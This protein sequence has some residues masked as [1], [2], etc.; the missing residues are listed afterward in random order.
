MTSSRQMADLLQRR[1]DGGHSHQPSEGGRY[2]DAAYYLLRLIQAIFQ[3]IRDTKNTKSLIRSEADDHRAMVNAISDSAGTLP[4]T[5]QAA[6][7]SKIPKVKGGS[8]VVT[9]SPE[10]F[11]A[12]YLDEYTGDV[13]DPELVAI[14]I[15]EE[16]DDFNSKVWQLELKSDTLLRPEHVFVRSRWVLCNKGDL[17][18]PDIRARLAACEINKGGDKPDNFFASTP[19][20]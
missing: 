6:H 17:R 13:L 18:N 7:T 14:A 20:A 9:Y 11:R 19:T 16:L 3:C 10:N 15:R 4:T 5:D 1:C 12:R 8:L 2:R